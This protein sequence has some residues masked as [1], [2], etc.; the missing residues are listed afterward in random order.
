MYGPHHQVSSNASKYQEVR[1]L[2]KMLDL[3][4]KEMFRF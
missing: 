4:V 3:N 1:V 2:P